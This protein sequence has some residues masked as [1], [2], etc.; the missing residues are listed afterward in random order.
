MKNRRISS[1]FLE[2]QNENK[3]HVSGIDAKMLPVVAFVH[4][5]KIDAG[6]KQLRAEK[7][8]ETFH[9]S[10]PQ[11]KRTNYC[12]VTLMMELQ[13]RGSRRRRTRWEEVMVSESSFL[14]TDV[15]EN[16][17]QSSECLIPRNHTHTHTVV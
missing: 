17:Q 1:F 11:K 14:R 2:N 10:E 3:I 12:S 16:L 7:K 8:T 13:Q 6:T 4:Q 15:H 9:R 5:V